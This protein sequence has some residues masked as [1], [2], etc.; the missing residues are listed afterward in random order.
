MP[1]RILFLTG[2]LAEKSLNRVLAAMRPSEFDYDVLNIG[3]SVAGL[4]TADL[5]RRRLPEPGQA[6]RILV[7]GRCRGDLEGLTS[8]YGVPVVR[9]PEELKDLPQF[10]GKKGVSE[11]LSRYDVRIFAEIVD[12][13]QRSLEQ[14][15]KRAENYRKDGADVIDLG[16]L[17]ETP[18]P[19]LEEAVAV[20]KSSGYQVSVD[21]VEPKEL[22]RGGKAGA[23]NLLSLKEDTL[24][25]AE[26]VDS[27]PVLI[28][29]QSGDL[30]SLERAMEKM[31]RS[32][33]RFIADP[34]LDPIHFGFTDSLVR[35]HGL[36]RRHPE[37]EIMMGVGNLT[38][39]TDAD[40]T[41]INALLMGIISELHITNI[42]TTEVSPHAQRAVREADAARRI[43]YTAR[44]A[45]S[46][47]RDFS[48]ELLTT[49]ARK[50]F[51]DTSEEIAELARAIKDP[52]YRIQI[53][54]QGIHIYNRDGLHVATEPFALFPL[55]SLE[56]DAAHAFYLGVELARAQIAWQL[57]KRYNQDEELDWGCAVE[58]K[59]EDLTQHHAPGTTLEVVK[60]KVKNK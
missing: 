19:H 39:L 2:H 10:F 6:T 26:E 41:G 9:G 18:F 36:R 30:A 56:N 23:D 46:L 60:K 55:L 5:I 54:E 24:W 20:L 25:V 37:T 22:L 35:Y 4:M 16:C 42:L 28:P 12:A 48:S 27:I 58:R 38:E 1:E 47:P 40:T 17:P 3:I 31:A 32:N 51:P 33:R 52:S 11:D 45:S 13:P 15:L 44:D 34:V 8:H 29:Q 59:P 53:S 43:M 21:S 7:P 57:A 14:I 49:H 50:P